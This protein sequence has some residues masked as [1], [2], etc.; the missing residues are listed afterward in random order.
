MTSEER[1]KVEALFDARQ[2]KELWPTGRVEHRAERLRPRQFQF[3]RDQFPALYVPFG[4]IEWH[5]RHMPLGNDALKAHG[6]CLAVAKRVGGIVHPPVFWGID[7]WRKL[8][9]GNIRRGMDATCDFPLPG[10]VYQVADDT[11]RRLAGDIVTEA[12]RNDFL[13]VVLLT[14]HNARNQEDTLREVAKLVNDASGRTQ[15]LATNDW[16]N[17]RTQYNWA[18]DHAGKWETTLMMGLHPDR[19]DMSELPAPPEKLTAT[20][21]IDPRGEASELLGRECLTVIIDT[22]QG[23]VWELMAKLRT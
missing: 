14:G 9:N 10:S 6:I 3:L 17:A 21:G 16:E 18:G 12:L 23:R 7:S 13:L 11:F 4:T 19:V 20:G 1:G 5:E 8:P 2:G 22:L 15:V